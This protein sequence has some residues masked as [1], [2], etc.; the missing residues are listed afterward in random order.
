MIESRANSVTPLQQG[1]GLIVWV[2]VTF[3][4]AA[5]GGYATSSSVGGWYHDL[6]KPAW[7]PPDWVFGPVWTVLYIMMAIAVWLVWRQGGVTTARWSLTLFI[8]QLALNVLWSVI[9]FGL[10]WP[11]LAMVEIVVLWLVLRL[12]LV[13]FWRRSR[14]A[15]L[16][17]WPYLTWVTFAAILNFQIA[18]LN[19]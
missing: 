2:L 6:V 15:G 16:M 19:G 12:T 3:A 1:V 7:T 18:R 8:T 14:V 13:A 11:W 17:L 4:A 9:L 5:L 10:Q